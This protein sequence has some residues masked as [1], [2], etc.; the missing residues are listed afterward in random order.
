M[1][2]RELREFLMTV[3]DDL[4]VLEENK[5]ELRRLRRED[6]HMDRNQVNPS[7]YYLDDEGELEEGTGV[8]VFGA[9]S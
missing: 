1:T 7:I 6:I 9:W 5:S 3:D 2:V 4:E 8:L